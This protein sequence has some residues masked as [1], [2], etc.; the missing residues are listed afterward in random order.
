MEERY[1]IK[2][3][4]KLGKN[5]IETYGMLQTAYGPSCMDRSLVF[6]WQKRFKEGREPVRDDEKCGRSRE[7]RTPE[8][9]AQIRNFMNEDRRVSKETISIKFDVSV[10]AAHTINHEQLKMQNICAKFVPRVLSE[11]QKERRHNNS[12]EMVEFIDPDP[13]VLEVLETRDESWIHCCDTE[14]KRQSFQWKHAGSPRPKKARESKSTQKLMTISLFDN[15]G[16][17]YALG[18]LWTDSQQR[19]LC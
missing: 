15:K 8:L 7:V 3:C 14:S 1:A 13:E 9:V 16:M 4:V 5:A 11:E 18:S 17:I 6:E 12:R 19:I 10:G 2:L